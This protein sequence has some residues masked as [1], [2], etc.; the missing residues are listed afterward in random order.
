[1]NCRYLQHRKTNSLRKT[2]R[3]WIFSRNQR[4]RIPV[5][6]MAIQRHWPDKSDHSSR[7]QDRRLS[8]FN[9]AAVG[10]GFSLLLLLGSAWLKSG[11]SKLAI[12]GVA[13]VLLAGALV[14]I[15]RALDFSSSRLANGTPR[16][17]AWIRI[18]VCLTALI[19]TLM[20]ALPGIASMPAGMRNDDQFFHVLNSLPGYSTLLSSPYLLATLQWTTAVLLFS[21]L[22]GFLTRP[23]LFLGSLGFF[24][25]QAIL[26]HYTY[27]YHSGLV[28][29]YLV[30]VITCTPCA[31]TWSIVSWLN[32]QK[33]QPGRQSFGFSV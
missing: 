28:L 13:A 8:R 9:P 6:C 23:T 20:E 21:G 16:Q 27:Q 12:S 26:R 3:R 31:A 22:I 15:F 29:I 14:K 17:L 25:M 10:L 1:M 11:G 32:H 19:Y 33:L 18:V 24:L 2:N 4:P 30:L 5:R 7:D